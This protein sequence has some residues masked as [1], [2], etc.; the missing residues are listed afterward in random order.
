MSVRKIVILGAGAFG[1][2]FAKLLE[3]KSRDYDIYLYDP[4]DYYIDGIN[5]TREHP[6]FHKGVKLSENIKA[7]KNYD[8]AV[9]NGDMY[10]LAIPSVFMREAMRI[11]K[12]HVKEGAILLN[13]S[14]ALEKGTNKRMSEVISEEMKGKKIHIA[15]LSG[16][17]IASDVVHEKRMMAD[18]GCQNQ[19]IGEKIC[20]IVSNDYFKAEPTLDLVGVELAG[21]FK[22]VVAIGAG[23]LDGEG[24]SYEKENYLEKATNEIKTLAVEMGAREETFEEGSHCWWGDLRATC[25]GDSRNRLFGELIGKGLTP[26]ESLKEMERQN[27]TVE[28]YNTTKVVYE[29]SISYGVKMPLIESLYRKLF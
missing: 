4:V 16:G 29:L 27:K 28:G 10:I 24:K 26:E 2:A 8:E 11:L 13:L 9:K 23:I 5:R 14:K 25:F 17:M 3:C 20:E 1:F 15:T 12:D 19:V 21:S 6:V 22:N 18:V 7:T